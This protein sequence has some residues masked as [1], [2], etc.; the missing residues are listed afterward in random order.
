LQAEKAVNY[1]INAKGNLLKSRL[2]YDLALFKMDMKGELIAQS[3]EQ[4][5]T[6]YHNAGRTSNDGAELA[7]SYLAL[8]QDDGK[9]ITLLRS[10]AAVTY[11]DFQF[12]DYKVLDADGDVKVAYDGNKL[13]GI[14]PW[15]VNAG[16]N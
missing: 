7:L 8:H 16:I 12:Q 5:I 10:Y 4:G 9:T 13:T 11:S 6:V 14:A 15:V 3:V 1:E 2:S